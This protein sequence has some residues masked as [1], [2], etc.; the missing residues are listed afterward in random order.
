MSADRLPPELRDDEPAGRKGRERSF[1]H[2]LR[3]GIRRAFVENLAL[4]FVA[5]VLAITLFILVNTDKDVS[6]RTSV[7]VSYTMPEDKVL[8]SDRVD[9]IRLTIQGPW[10]RI[11]GFDERELERIHI[12]LTGRSEGV[13]QFTEE[14]IK[15]PPGLELLAL[16][17]PDMKLDFDERA[18]KTVPV[19]VARAGSPARGY[20]VEE[21][22]ANP[23]VVTV[24]G[25]AQVVSA[26]SAVRTR[27]INLQGRKES[28]TE[29]VSLLS[30]EDY[31][32]IV[33]GP[34]VEV[35]IGLEEEQITRSFELPVV[36]RPATVAVPRDAAGDFFT[37]PKQVTVT[38]QGSL[39]LL[40]SLTPEDVVPYVEIF[41]DD[42][43]DFTER[44]ALVAVDVP[45]GD[46]IRHNITPTRVTL[47][48]R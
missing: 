35:R 18:E 19:N 48:R 22:S 6:I 7:G 37:E 23:S 8:V 9:Q 29:T 28:F 12:D 13:L 38:L 17:P 31:V 21:V 5:M 2:D 10:R 46:E 3:G 1:L 15:L 4:K 42:V 40:E 33:G 27:E 16:S 41:A 45:H 39:L 24:R 32:D 26:I 20:K 30:P 11:K 14:M 36:A 25:A 44:P 47:G 34:E 43:I